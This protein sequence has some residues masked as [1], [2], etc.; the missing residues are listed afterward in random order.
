MIKFIKYHLLYLFNDL[1][2]ILAVVMCI[3]S[4]FLFFYLGNGFDSYLLRLLEK[5]NYLK[6]FE[7]EG[8]LVCNLVLSFWIINASKEMF[9][10]NDPNIMVINKK[11]YV[12]SKIIAYLIYYCF[13]SVLV[14]GMYQLIVFILYG[15]VKY[16][17]NFIIHLLFN[18]CLIHLIIV[19]FTGKNKNM[20][21]SVIY[22]IIYLIFN[23]IMQTEFYLK[24]VIHF[25][26]PYLNLNLPKFGYIHNILSI[27][28][29][30]HIASYRHISYY[31]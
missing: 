18:V 19:L 29:L 20:L 25:F 17:Y 24:S 14:Y 16:N 12:K 30:Y 15:T 11:K 5:N 31:D 9:I 22:L 21:L 6:E 1:W 7:H 8:F 28:F 2:L 23:T 13:I 4:A 3:V 26:I 27:S 10:I